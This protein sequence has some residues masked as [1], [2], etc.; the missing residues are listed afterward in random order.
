MT[1]DFDLWIDF[2][3]GR[4]SSEEPVSVFRRHDLA[5]PNRPE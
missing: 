5:E 4:P 1:D 3:S 2:N